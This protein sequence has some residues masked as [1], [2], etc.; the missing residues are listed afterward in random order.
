M[1]RARPQPGERAVVIGA[2]GIGAFIVCAAARAG[3]RTIAVDVSQERLGIAETLGAETTIGGDEAKALPSALTERGIEPAIV[4]EVTGTEAGLRSALAITEPA[5]ARVVLTGLHEQPREIDLRR[6]TLREVEL[7]GT[8]A[9]VCSV[10]LP[11]AV[12]LL[13]ARREGW[14]DIAPQAFP[15]ADVLAE[16]IVPIVERRAE[17]IKTLI[18]PWADAPRAADTRP[19]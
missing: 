15:L 1:R 5:G 7:I 2:G 18:D 6:I 3:L 14:A 4:Y 8:N 19:R 17:R 10:D 12:S 11:E 9:H 13:A 16:G